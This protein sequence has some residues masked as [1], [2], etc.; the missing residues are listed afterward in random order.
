MPSTILPAPSDRSVTE[1]TAVRV[2]ELIVGRT[3]SHPIFD[4]HGILL[5]AQGQVI[6]PEIKR[7]L[8]ARS[9]NFVMIHAADLSSVTL[10]Q[11]AFPAEG[12]LPLS[13]EITQKLDE[14][15]E[16]GFFPVANRGPAVKQSVAPHG[17]TGYDPPQRAR[18]VDSH[19]QNAANLTELM[20]LALHGEPVDG[21]VVVTMTTHYLQDLVSDTDNLLTSIAA[22][23]EREEFSSNCLEV[24]LLSMAIAVEMDLDADNVRDIGVCGL[25]HDW[26]MLRVPAEIRNAPRRLNDSE[27][28]EITKHPMHSLEILQKI[29]A[30]PRI[31]PLVV[32]QIHER[33]NGCGYPRGRTGRNIHPF[34][35]IVHVA[36]S[37]TSLTSP[38]PYRPPLMRYSAMECLV[39]QARDRYVDP[40]VV[41]ALLRIQSLFP[42]GSLVALSDGS[43]ARVLRPN[44]DEY[45]RPIVQRVQHASGATADPLD[46]ENVID[47]TNSPLAIRQA[48]PTPGRNE[49]SL[50]DNVAEIR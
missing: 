17:R 29:S 5:L 49:T 24:S 16:R 12:G 7:N 11:A 23:F 13:Q 34:A 41:R 20:Q 33:P 2:D 38:R 45:T 4:E 32:Y 22:A 30:L 27:R 18:M 3:T 26:G 19:Q 36:D 1:T 28:V 46:D 21:S 50:T 47:L 6:T 10:L 35:K 42:L 40:D 43:I 44:R 39:R 8:R 15:I 48:L 14:I 25:V 9:G 31:T 37:Y